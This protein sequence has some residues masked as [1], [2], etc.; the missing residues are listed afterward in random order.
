MDMDE[1]LE[2]IR[3]GAIAAAA[4]IDPAFAEKVEEERAE[5][6]AMK[7]RADDLE[8]KKHLKPD[9]SPEEKQ[10]V[11]LAQ[12]IQNRSRCQDGEIRKA[13]AHLKAQK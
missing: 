10:W 6:A 13:E 4:A 1:A 5:I 11:T 3:L 9:P 7:K 8:A 2:K 12:Q